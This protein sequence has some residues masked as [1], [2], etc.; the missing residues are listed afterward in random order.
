[1]CHANPSQ[2]QQN[3]LVFNDHEEH[4]HEKDGAELIKNDVYGE[5]QAINI[6]GIHL[7]N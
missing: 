1:M 7:V 5:G 6:Y 3:L 2:I 4:S